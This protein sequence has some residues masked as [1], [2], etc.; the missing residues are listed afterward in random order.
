MD[1][2]EYYPN[3]PLATT[4]ANRGQEK[5]QDQGCYS[6]SAQFE[7]A[8]GFV[9]VLFSDRNIPEAWEEGFEVKVVAHLGKEKTPDDWADKGKPDKPAG[10]TGST[11]GGTAKTPS[12]GA[13]AR[14]WEIADKLHAEQPLLRADRA[15]VIAA[16]EEAGIAKAT[17]STQW[18]KW[19]KARGI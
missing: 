19:A 9:A 14:V 16:C 18:S 10:S 5:Y 3:R 2:R 12:R 13:T 6:A 4:A 8:K 1:T 7:P 17:A 15:R 11:G